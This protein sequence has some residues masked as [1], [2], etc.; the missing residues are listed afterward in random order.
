MTVLA[1]S[2][3][4]S[5]GKTRTINRNRPDGKLSKIEMLYFFW[6]HSEFVIN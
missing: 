6:L 4:F 2:F 3:H 5:S 1:L